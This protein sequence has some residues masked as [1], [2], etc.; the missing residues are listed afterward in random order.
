MKYFSPEA[1]AWLEKDDNLKFADYFVG[2][3]TDAKDR[4]W[5]KAAIEIAAQWCILYERGEDKKDLHPTMRACIEPFLDKASE[6]EDPAYSFWAGMCGHAA[7]YRFAE[8]DEFDLTRAL[9]GIYRMLLP[10]ERD[11]E[12]FDEKIFEKLIKESGVDPNSANQFEYAIKTNGLD[13]KIIM[14]GPPAAK[15]WT[16]YADQYRRVLLNL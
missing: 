11:I 16:E 6:S 5:R 10:E 2:L 7:A 15:A 14:H 3:A 9:Y 1:R 4:K 12:P 13:S 8:I